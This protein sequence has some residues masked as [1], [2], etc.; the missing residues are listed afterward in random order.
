M[1][2][3]YD[4]LGVDHEEAHPGALRKGAGSQRSHR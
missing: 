4:G 3:K 2:L 1:A